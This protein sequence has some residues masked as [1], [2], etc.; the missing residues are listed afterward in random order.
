MTFATNYHDQIEFDNRD[1]ARYQTGE[2]RMPMRGFDPEYPDIVDY[3]IR[4]THRIWEEKDVGYIYDT[5]QHNCVIHDSMG[6]RHGREGVVASTLQS[7]AAFSE[8]RLYADDVIWSGNQDDGF[9]TSHLSTG[10]SYNRGYS[11][12]GPPTG[13]KIVSRAIANCLSKD[14]KI[15]EEWLL[16]DDSATIRQMG[17]DVNEV[18]ERQVRSALDTSVYQVPVSDPMRMLGQYAP[19]PLATHPHDG[20]DVE[21]FVRATYHDIWNRRRLNLVAQRYAPSHICSTSGNRRFQGTGALTAF[22]LNMLALFPDAEI[23][24]DHVY[25]NGDDT[26]GYRVAVRWTLSGT[27][28][29]YGEYG[30]PS[31]ARILA[32]GLSQHT[33]KNGLFVQESSLFDEMSILR[34]IAAQR[35]TNS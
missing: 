27:H 1:I 12:Y 7:L 21:D 3:I 31:R 2:R 35:I 24:V 9:H 8:C 6:D 26:R 15:F 20:F 4:I 34:Q 32:M 33:I 28:A 13:R 25:W 10:I 30:P 17:Y 14:N 16:H 29:G 23:S 11:S 19:A 22:M 5:Y 18:A